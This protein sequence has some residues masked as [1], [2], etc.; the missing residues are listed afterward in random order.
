MAEWSDPRILVAL[1]SGVV[2]SLMGLG[3]IAF[4]AYVFVR[5]RRQTRKQA[6]WEEYRD[7]VYDPLFSDV[8]RVEEFAKR[9]RGVRGPPPG[10]G[11]ARAFLR[12]LSELMNE[13]EISCAKADQHG[14]STERDWAECA[15]VKNR[16]IHE[17]ID[18]HGL[19]EEAVQPDLSRRQALS[20]CLQ[21][22]VEFF[23]D[24]L[25]KQRKS[26]LDF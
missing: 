5:Q 17:L 6:A 4:S 23:E 16:E 10:E 8:R 9:C 18:A 26:L 13:V 11:D 20:A 1:G 22:Y 7:T 2:G 15:E 21:A 25:R 24:R 14:A 12:D 19:A 3:S